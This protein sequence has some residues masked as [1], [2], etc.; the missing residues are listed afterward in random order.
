MECTGRLLLQKMFS[1]GIGDFP[2]VFGLNFFDF[3]GSQFLLLNIPS[4]THIE[5]SRRMQRLEPSDPS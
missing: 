4:V 1:N 3:A 5:D 2:A